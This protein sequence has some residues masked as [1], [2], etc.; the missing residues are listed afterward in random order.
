ME[1]FT[2]HMVNVWP[3]LNSAHGDIL[4]TPTTAQKPGLTATNASDVPTRRHVH[5]TA[6]L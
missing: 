2:D 5:T 4:P 6:P 3:F 1:R